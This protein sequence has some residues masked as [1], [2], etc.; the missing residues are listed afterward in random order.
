MTKA[1]PERREGANV[2]IGDLRRDQGIA[3]MDRPNIVDW[4][5][6]M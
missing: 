4:R 3:V 6:A 2:R 5:A 1:Y